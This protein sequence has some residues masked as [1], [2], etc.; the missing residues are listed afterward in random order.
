MPRD[1][2]LSV[3][4]S[5]AIALAVLS[6]P[7]SAEDIPKH[8]GTLEVGTVYAT[9][10]PL[11]WNPYDWQWKVNH[12]T[13]MVYDLLLAADLSKAKRNG[14]PHSFTADAWVPG[15]A[16]R[17]DLAE[18]YEVR[19]N[20]LSVVFRLRKGRDVSRQ[21]GRHEVARTDVG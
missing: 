9:L 8:G 14:G 13:G 4:S 1:K 12:D 16:V 7:A 18:S 6:A 5:L 2:K 3:V 20:P 21:G 11:T 10:S 17:G 19:E 15:D